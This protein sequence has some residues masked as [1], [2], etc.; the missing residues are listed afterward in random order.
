MHGITRFDGYRKGQSELLPEDT[1][2]ST[3]HPLNSP[4]W[5]V[6][7]GSNANTIIQRDAKIGATADQDFERVC[8]RGML[9]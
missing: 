5:V 8:I 9:R 1:T 4:G 7:F 6:C 3:D 2:G